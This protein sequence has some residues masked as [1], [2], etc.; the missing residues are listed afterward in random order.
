MAIDVNMARF[1]VTCQQNGV[2][3]GQ[4]LTL[5][6][7]N[8]YLGTKE[9]RQL[10]RWSGMD[11]R[12]HARLLDYQ[13]SRHAETFFQSLGAKQVESLDAS[14]FEG[15]SIVHD[16][17]AP[18]PESLKG[19]FDTVCDAGT[20]EHVI[21]FPVVIRNAMEMVKVGGHLILGTPANN[22][23]GHG[24]YQFSPELWFRLLSPDRGFE[25]RR[26]VAVEYGPRAR[27]FEVAD[28]AVVKDRVAMTNRRP[29]LLMIVA[30]KLADKPILD[31][32]PQQSDYV[33]R[34]EGAGD[35]ASRRLSL[36]VSFRRW[37]LEIA[38]QVARWLENFYLYS[39]FN[40][41]N[42]LRNRK[43]FKPVKR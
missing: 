34:W 10:L 23:F 16:L 32:F 2:D 25:M 20:I 33:P 21:N 1:L 37:F 9:T 12:Q 41:K 38:P 14:S 43:F 29:V 11:P 42:S 8:Y 7:L 22:F 26:M 27:W 18:V 19:K 30:K 28:P 3:F 36:E 5:G 15:A 40:R 6:R 24:F 13:S 31:A 17:N 4:T 35:P 39:W